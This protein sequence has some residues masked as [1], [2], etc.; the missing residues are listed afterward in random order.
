MR[1]LS[2]QSVFLLCL[3][4]M[5]AYSLMA[6]PLS[7]A[8][9]TFAE[10][11][12]KKWAA[13]YQKQDGATEIRYDAVGSGEGIKRLLGKQVDFG[14]SD[15]PIKRTELEEKG[16]R[17][18]PVAMGAVVPVVNLPG[19]PAGALKLNGELLSKIYQG[20]ITRWNDKQ[21]VEINEVVGAKLPDL[22][23]KPISREDSSGTTFAFTYY[24]SGRSAA[25]KKARG[26]GS[27]MQGLAGGL[28]AKGTSGV[29][30]LLKKTLGS[31][32]YVDFGRV[33][34]DQ[35]NAVQLPNHFGAFIKVGIES[36]LATSKFN[37]EKLVYTPDPDFYLVLADN[38]TYAGW[39]LATA[40]FVMIPKESAQA[41]RIFT[42]L[43]FAFKQ[44]DAAASE[45]GYV[46]L[47]ESMKLAVR[48][49]WSRQFGFKA[50]Q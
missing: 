1:I 38:D 47:S 7:G 16:L 14:A 48:K 33:V 5:S 19:I 28:T 39:P 8:G 45:L 41:E 18:Y 2:M 35:L 46:P 17:Q 21:I 11:L 29:V 30:D 31:I 43:F 34:R 3:G 4:W 20:Q 50:S 26:V 23:I 22:P 12:Y 37:E 36:I 13:L 44:G 25:W 40:T 6:A 10:P 15:E 9:S 42:F 32:A 49:S 24:L 27:T